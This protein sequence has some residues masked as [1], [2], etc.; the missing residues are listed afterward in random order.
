MQDRKSPGVPFAPQDFLTVTIA[1]ST[2]GARVEHIRLPDPQPGVDYLILVQKP[3]E[4]AP[5]SL[6]RICADRPDVSLSRLDSLGLSNSRNAALRLAQGDLVLFSDD[7]VILILSGVCALRDCFS[8]DPTLVL[9]AGWRAGRPPRNAGRGRLT[10]LNSGRICAPEFMVRR[11]SIHE[12]GVQF[13]LE[14]GRGARHGV[15]EDY[16]FVTDILRAGARGRTFP[17]VTGSHPGSST[18]DQWNDPALLAARRAVLARVFGIWA[19]PVRMA[20]VVRHRQRFGSI[21]RMMRFVAG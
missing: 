1:I 7:D 17:V 18:G 13:D 3:Q 9:A 8:A 21:R 4:A 14:F 10:R 5:A 19:L 16:V 12:I 6:D 20:Y 11:L 15:G 2:L